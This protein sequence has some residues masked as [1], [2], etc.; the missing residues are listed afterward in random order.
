MSCGRPVGSDPTAASGGASAATVAATVG[1][2]FG[3]FA[4]A[5]GSLFGL[6]CGYTGLVTGDRLRSGVPEGG[7]LSLHGLEVLGLLIESG[8]GS[9]GRFLCGDH[10]LLCNLLQAVAF[11][12]GD[13]CL[14]RQR[15]GGVACRN[16]VIVDRLVVLEQLVHGAQTGQQLIG[17]GRGTGEEQLKC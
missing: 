9:V 11:V 17:I 4:F 15:L 13:L 2:R 8:L 14:I 3:G 6:A 10:L 1:C 7:E 16:S 5:A 12:A